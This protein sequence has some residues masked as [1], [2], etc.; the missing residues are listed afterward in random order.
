MTTHHCHLRLKQFLFII[1]SLLL[2]CS[3]NGCKKSEPPKRPPVPV[4]TLKIVPQTIPANFE[5]LGFAESSHLVQIR[6]RVEGYL[7][8]IAYNE[9][10]FVHAGDLLFQI[11]QRPFEDD[12]QEARGEMYQQQA[13]L[14]KAIRAVDR[15]KPL[16]E[17]KAASQKDLDDAT[18]FQLATEANLYT[19]KG[20]VAKAELNLSYTTVTTPIS[21]LSSRSIFREGALVGPGRDSLLTTISMVDPIWI[22]FTV[23]ENDLLKYHTEEKKGNL[24]F[25]KGLNFDVEVILA[26]DTSIPGIGKV[27]FANPTIDQTTGTMFVRAVFPNPKAILKP[28]QYLK[29]N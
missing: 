29:Q 15:L 25:P 4:Q 21:G 17:K 23:S 1:A 14:W 7:L 24:V 12:L 22:T 10:G 9:G 18:A 26:D 3:V 28:G 27:D 16:Y 2:I 11:D 19:A 8:K 5:Y 20:K 13:L 6:A